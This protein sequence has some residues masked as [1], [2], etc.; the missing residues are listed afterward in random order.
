MVRVLAETD[1]GVVPLR[2]DPF[3]DEATLQKLLARFPELVL[4][5]RPEDNRPKIWTI[6]VE[7]PVPSGSI[8]LVLLDAT[9]RVWV[10]ETK[11][12]KNP[13][14]RKHVVGQVLGYASDVVLWGPEE[15]SSTASQHLGGREL[16]E[17]IDESLGEGEGVDVV[18]RA[19]QRLAS[20]DLTA[21]IVVDSFNSVLRRL[22][23][24]VNRY[25][26][27]ELLAM[28]VQVATHDGKR[29]FFPTVVG[30]QS[31]P[32]PA[33]P[34]DAMDYEDL[35]AAAAPEVADLERHLDALAADQGWVARVAPKSKRYELPHGPFLFRLYPQ[36]EMLEFSFQRFDDRPE[37]LI[38]LRHAI[39]LLAGNTRPA[40]YPNLA[41]AGDILANWEAVVTTVLLPYADAV[42]T[43]G[44]D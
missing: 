31:A 4:G 41:G 30:E 12:A 7:V 27:F 18:E 11:L 9:G 33:R 36:W 21:L 1:S 14:V 2:L 37:L 6:G 26:T 22:V 42:A 28:Q 24:F 17:L 16:S 44:Q 3:E 38:P 32:K 8:D 34:S 29:L 15:L 43:L 13:E 35:L 23:E 10:V 25:A 19:A 5:G 39:E 20:G 40:K